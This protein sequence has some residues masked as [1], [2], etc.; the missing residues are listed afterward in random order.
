MVTAAPGDCAQVLSRGSS[1][2]ATSSRQPWSLRQAQLLGLSETR[3]RVEPEHSPGQ[4]Q[5]G[6]GAPFE[7]VTHAL[8][9]AARSRRCTNR[10]LI[11][12]LP[13]GGRA[14]EGAGTGR[15]VPT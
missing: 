4:A 14:L 5:K 6:A 7:A 8:A 9:L 10:S 3:S 2:L 15:G 11:N 1:W 12:L 13:D